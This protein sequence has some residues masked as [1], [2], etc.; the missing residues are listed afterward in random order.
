MYMSARRHMG[1]GPP[2]EG[3]L[4]QMLESVS[5]GSDFR[6]FHLVDFLG[7]KCT[8]RRN[9]GYAY[10]FVYS[11]RHG[12]PIG[13]DHEYDGHWTDGLMV[14]I[15][16]HGMQTQSSD[17]NSVRLSNACIVTKR[18]KAMFRLLYHTKEHLS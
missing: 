13:V 7:K 4:P 14:F 16:L 6:V 8:P 2:G 11:G 12:H 18:K 1:K 15:A 5:E 9:P 17:E 3:H 10:E